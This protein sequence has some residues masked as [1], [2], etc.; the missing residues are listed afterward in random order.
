MYKVEIADG[1]H[2]QTLE[3]ARGEALNDTCGKQV[4]VTNLRFTN[5]G[6]DDVEQGRDDEDRSFAVFATEG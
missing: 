3:C 4:L 1:G 5:R 2:D 6:A